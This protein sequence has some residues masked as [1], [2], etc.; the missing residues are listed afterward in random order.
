MQ[1]IWLG[2]KDL[3]NETGNPDFY[4]DEFIDKRCIDTDFGRRVVT[5]C[6]DVFKVM[7]YVT[8]ELPT[9][10]L[11]SPKELSSGAKSLLI[12]A[13]S[14]EDVVCDLVWCGENCEIFID[15]LASQKDIT[16]MTSRW[17]VPN[18]SGKYKYDI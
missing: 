13:F 3:E 10:E 5:A 4:F 14:D 11:I 16:V 18:K 2:Y 7:N 1:N 12:M 17:Y 6:S 9:G 8:L 15:E